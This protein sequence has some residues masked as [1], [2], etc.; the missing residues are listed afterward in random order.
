MK[1]W[2]VGWTNHLTKSFHETTIDWSEIEA[3]LIKWGELFLAGK[4]LRVNI[5]FNYIETG[6]PWPRHLETQIKGAPL[7]TECSQTQIHSL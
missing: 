4:K 3:Q 5:S 1:W 2:G 6:Q 7:P